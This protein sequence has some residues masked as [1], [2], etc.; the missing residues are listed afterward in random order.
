MEAW[1]PGLRIVGP[2][3][4]PL[5]YADWRVGMA[6]RFFVITTR[7]SGVIG[8]HHCLLN[9]DLACD[10]AVLLYRASAYHYLDPSSAS[11]FNDN[12]PTPQH[13]VSSTSNHLR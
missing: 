6:S 8:A 13:V 3:V 11:V 5:M 7:M 12:S 10:N 9:V 2:A 4:H 1:R